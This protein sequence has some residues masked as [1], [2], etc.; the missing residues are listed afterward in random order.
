[1][2]KTNPVSSYCLRSTLQ[3]YLQMVGF[4]SI[5]KILNLS[6]R[7]CGRRTE[8]AKSSIFLQVPINHFETSTF[9]LFHPVHSHRISTSAFHNI[10]PSCSH[11]HTFPSLVIIHIQ[12]YN[13]SRLFNISFLLFVSRFRVFSSH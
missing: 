1:M 11:L 5:S 7:S 9:V 12:I 10:P 8:S 4:S 13:L 6:T 2:L 3:L